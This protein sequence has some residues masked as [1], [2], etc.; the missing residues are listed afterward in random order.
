MT[1]SEFWR[2]WSKAEK[3]LKKLAPYPTSNQKQKRRRK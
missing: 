2:R 1:L 3:S